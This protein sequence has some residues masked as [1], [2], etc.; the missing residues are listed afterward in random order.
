MREVKILVETASPY[1]ALAPG[2][3]LVLGAEYAAR[4]VALGLAEYA[5][6]PEAAVAVRASRRA[7]R[8]RAG[9]RNG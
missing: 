9:R 2:E 7:V 1:G 5:D 6:A 4:L 3:T 8:P